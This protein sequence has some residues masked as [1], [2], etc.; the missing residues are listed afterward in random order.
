L[1][2]DDT[3]RLELANEWGEATMA[4]VGIKF[5]P[6]AIWEWLDYIETLGEL[7]RSSAQRRRKLIAGFPES[8]DVITSP[9]RLKPDLGFLLPTLIIALRLASQTLTPVSQTYM[10]CVR[11]SILS[12]TI[13]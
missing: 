9:E 4:K 10:L 12:G 1:E 3:T 5:T 11:R 6:N 8:F 2:Y 13:G 7:G